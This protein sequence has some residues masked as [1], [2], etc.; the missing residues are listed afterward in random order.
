MILKKM[1]EIANEYNPETTHDIWKFSEEIERT[2]KKILL[3][4]TGQSI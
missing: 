3:K 1:E 4:I 2:L